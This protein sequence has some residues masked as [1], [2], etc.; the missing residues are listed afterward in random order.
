M[1][2]KESLR[3][4]VITQWLFSWN[5]GIDFLRHQL[6]ALSEVTPDESIEVFLFFQKYPNPLIYKSLQL[7]KIFLKRIFGKDVRKNLIKLRQNQRTITQFYHLKNHNFS[8][9]GYK[10]RKELEH[11]LIENKI[12]A[13][14]FSDKELSDIPNVF[15]YPDFQHKHLTDF[16]SVEEIESRDKSLK[17]L[18][19]KPRVILLNSKNAKDDLQHFFPDEFKRCKTFCLPYSPMILQSN[20]L[21]D[22]TQVDVV[23][24][25]N[26]PS[27]YFLISNQFWIHK[28]HDTAFR[29]LADL[30]QDSNFSDVKIICTGAPYDYR[31]PEH[32]NNL[33]AET[34]ILGIADKISYLGLIPKREQIEIMKK[35]VALIQ[36]TLFEGDPGGGSYYDA[37]SIGV[38]AIISDIAVNLEAQ[39][40]DQ[41]TFFHVQNHKDLS[42]K[43]RMILLTKFDKKSKDHL[44]SVSRKRAI[45]HGKALLEAIY[46]GCSYSRNC[47]DL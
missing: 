27:R 5:G 40:E 30:N 16:F 6:N 32:F 36:P 45:K 11:K 41:T 15:Y 3:I 47:S 21:D 26:L 29:A 34:R 22:L 33:V 23:K 14:L 31:F 46:Y 43:M 2:K 35:S 42:E 17:E 12:S 8:F 24:K 13:T 7:S 28:S 20:W 18:F 37:V 4:G 10:N 44:L 25:Y 1:T 39:G 38:P 19:S 9:V